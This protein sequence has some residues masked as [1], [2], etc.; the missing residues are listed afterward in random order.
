MYFQVRGSKIL[1]FTNQDIKKSRAVKN[2]LNSSE[3]TKKL[4]ETTAPP[5]P[6]FAHKHPRSNRLS[7]EQAERIYRG[8]N[9]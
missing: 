3:I 1:K 8:S 2:N 5:A 4:E 9:S 6:T 7:V